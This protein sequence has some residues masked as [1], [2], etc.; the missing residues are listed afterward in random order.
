[1]DESSRNK[2]SAKFDILEWWNYLEDNFNIIQKMIKNYEHDLGKRKNGAA[3]KA[4]IKMRAK[5]A[6]M[7]L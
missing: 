1:M 7:K 4:M 6:K 3:K 5:I 2:V